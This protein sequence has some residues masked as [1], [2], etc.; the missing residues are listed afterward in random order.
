MTQKLQR[1]QKKRRKLSATLKSLS[2][3]EDILQLKIGMLE[4]TAAQEGKQKTIV[5]HSP[6][7]QVSAKLEKI[8]ENLMGEKPSAKSHS[9]IYHQFTFPGRNATQVK[10][11][12][13]ALRSGLDFENRVR[14]QKNVVF[15]WSYKKLS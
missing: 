6:V 3:K 12:T 5:D 10:E 4:K 2:H 15:S 9:G 8:A 13:T 1:L 11:E 14:V 7:D